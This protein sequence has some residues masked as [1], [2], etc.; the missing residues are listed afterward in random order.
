METLGRSEKDSEHKPLDKQTE[1]ATMCDT[2]EATI[3]AA[4]MDEV[5]IITGDKRARY[6][7]MFFRA[8]IRQKTNAAKKVLAKLSKAVKKEVTVDYSN[9][10]GVA[11]ITTDLLTYSYLVLAGEITRGLNYLSNRNVEKTKFLLSCASD[12]IRI[13]H[14]WK[15]TGYKEMKSVK[16]S[17]ICQKNGYGEVL[18]IIET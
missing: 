12:K 1:N 4:R 17:E 9:K 8:A 3:G 13:I 18:G 11:H 5:F 7:S 10:D 14:K 2:D 16:Q 15:L 6:V